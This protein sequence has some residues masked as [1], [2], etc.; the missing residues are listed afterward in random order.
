MLAPPPLTSEFVGMVSY[1]PTYFYELVDNEVESNGSNIGDVAPSHRPSRECVMA[2]ASGEPPVVAESL[3][4]HTPLDPRAGALVLAQEHGEE[5]RQQRQNQPP[6]APA[7]SVQHVA[8]YAH[9][10]AGSARGRARHVQHDIM[11]EGNDPPQFARASQN[12]AITAMLLHG[13]P[14]PID[15]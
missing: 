12:I 3:Q 14:E 11:N 5:L 6:P 9:N 15:P 7:S 8:P 4:T 10:P 2:D 1:A 13:V